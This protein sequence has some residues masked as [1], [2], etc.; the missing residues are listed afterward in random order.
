[1]SFPSPGTPE[2]GKR[3][4]GEG[5][6]PRDS[7]KALTPTLSRITGRGGKEI[8]AII[9][10]SCLAKQVQHP[11]FIRTT[12]GIVKSPELISRAIACGLKKGGG[13]HPNPPPEYQG[14]GDMRQMGLS[15]SSYLP[16]TGF[17]LFQR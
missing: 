8:T 7:P 5:R 1:M 12:C 10:R 9:L 13:P 15:C 4:A 16:K 3:G 2:E 17:L 6:F 14:R 11:P